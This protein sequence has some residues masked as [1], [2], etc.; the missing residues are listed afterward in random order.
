MTELLPCPCC[1]EK[2]EIYGHQ[3]FESYMIHC[4][5]WCVL[6][7]TKDTLEEAINIWNKRYKSLDPLYFEK[8]TK[9]ELCG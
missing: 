1:G 5:N 2:A 6:S 8:L 3:Y 7:L 9:E 4:I